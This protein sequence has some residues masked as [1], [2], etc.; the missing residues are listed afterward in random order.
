M[1]LVNF[2]SCNFRDKLREM[3]LF[4]CFWLTLYYYFILIYGLPFGHRHTCYTSIYL[5]LSWKKITVKCE[6]ITADFL[7]LKNCE[8]RGEFTAPL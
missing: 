3:V 1:R 2:I 6:Q 8:I 4:S 7:F 5:F